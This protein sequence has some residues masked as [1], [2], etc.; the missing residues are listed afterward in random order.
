MSPNTCLKYVFNAP[1]NFEKKA[2]VLYYIVKEALA[3]NLVKE[4]A[5]IPAYILSRV[6]DFISAIS[7]R[8]SAACFLSSEVIV[9]DVFAISLLIKI[10]LMV[11]TL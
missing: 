6:P 2:F 9:G 5:I 11:F 7:L 1:P 3:K 4:V 10:G 8:Y